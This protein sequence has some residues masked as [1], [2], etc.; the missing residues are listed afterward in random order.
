MP[1][2]L[3]IW[4][5]RILTFWILSSAWGTGFLLKDCDKTL[6]NG[7][8]DVRGWS[9]AEDFVNIIDEIAIVF[10]GVDA[11]DTIRDVS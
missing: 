2:L 11:A 10:E 7:R 9:H 3:N 1:Y 4:I 6:T 8:K 5:D